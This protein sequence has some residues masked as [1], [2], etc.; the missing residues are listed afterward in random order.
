MTKIIYIDGVFDLFHRGHLESLKKAKN[1]YGN[2]D[3]TH[4]I[5]GV[6]SDID[7]ESYKRKPIISEDDRV[8]IVKSINIVN[9]IVFPCPLILTIDFIK[10]HNID[11]VVHGF[12]NNNDKQNQELFFCEIKDYFKEI[13][14]YDKTS[15]TAIIN[16]IKNS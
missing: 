5:V 12:S 7:C 9:S 1:Y 6:V 4:L 16:K 3:D 2:P 13:E 14:Y 10:M 11:I 8:E 15:T